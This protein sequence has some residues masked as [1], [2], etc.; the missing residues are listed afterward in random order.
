MRLMCWDDDI[1][2][3][4]NIHLTDADYWSRLGADICFDP[5]FKSY[6]D[7]NRGLRQRFAAPTSLPMKLENMSYYQ[8]PRVTMKDASCDTTGSTTAP[9]DVSKANQLYCQ[10]IMSAIVQ[11][12]CQGLSHLAHIPVRFGTFDH[13]MPL[14]SHASINHEIRWWPFPVFNFVARSTILCYARL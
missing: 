12:D 6:L 3:R 9:P 1:I 4:N 8:G 2:H 14:S 11:G 7:F 13:V 5:L 10:L